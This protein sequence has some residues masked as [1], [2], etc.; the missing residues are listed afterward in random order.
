[1]TF[2]M[3]TPL[4]YFMLISPFVIPLILHLLFHKKTDDFKRIIGIVLSIVAILLLVARNIEIFILRGYEFDFELLPLQVCHFANFVM[5]YAYI[6]RSDVVFGFSFLFNMPLAYFSLLFA[7]G[8]ENYSNILNWRGQAYIWGHIL[9]VSITFYAYIIGFIKLNLKKFISV[10]KIVSILVFLSVF[11]NNFFRVFFDQ[12]ANYFYTEHP[13]LGTPLEFFYNLGEISY[14]GNFEVNIIY[15]VL[16]GI[17]GPV[18]I[19]LF[20]GLVFEL[21]RV[22]KEHHQEMI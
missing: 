21:P 7:D 1:M 13:E 6:K 18:V 4:H 17:A 14:I 2:T 5:L 19:F 16:L 20:Y 22:I 10:A 9:I 15:T 11:V 12:R 8:L 3:W